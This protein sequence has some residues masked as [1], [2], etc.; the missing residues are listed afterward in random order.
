[1]KK[2]ALSFFAS[3]LLANFSF[4]QEFL[5]RPALKLDLSLFD[6]P[7][8]IG[9]AKT[10]EYGFFES[11]LH[12]TMDASLNVTNGVYSSL[13]FGLGKLRAA[14]GTDAYWK[15]VAYYGGTM[16]G[17]FLL[18]MLPV[19]AGFFWM[20]ESFHGAEFTHA[21][22]RNHMDYDFP[23]GA[24]TVGD[25][26]NFSYWHDVPRTVAAGMEGEVLL[27]DKMQRNNFFYDQKM[28]HE[29]AYWLF[30]YQTWSYAYMP[31]LMGDM[32]MTIDGKEEAVSADSLQWAYSLFHPHET[33]PDEQAITMSDLSNGAKSYLENR[34]WWSLANF[35]SPM[36]F[37]I[38]SIPLGRD[39][40]F[41]GNFALRQMY[42]SFGTDLSV[43]IY[44]KKY[45]FNIAFA[46][47][48]YVNYENYFPAIEAE[49]VDYPIQITPKFG[50]LLSPRV[51]L[52]MQPRGQE[53]M[54]SEAEFFGLIGA[55][56]D[57]AVGG[58]FLPYLAF[59]LKTDGWVAGDE[60][61]EKNAGIKFGVS[62]RL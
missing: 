13:H 25:S 6:V 50:L 27:V 62:A 7:Y 55:R 36:M 49:L 43:N 53:F 11:Y 56:V 31:F 2:A 57:F 45:P 10:L 3:F 19:P 39:T 29:F 17:D 23:K 26:G 1:M 4:A 33:V 40:G 52:G 42:T 20:H 14:I 47:H 37:G 51:M 18:Y 59:V 34:V 8:Q 35:V 12:P 9:A 61:L 54:A 48:N 32:T 41:Y 58:H 44:L 30:A 46:Y 15:R 38:R 24:Y 5:D 28:F 16:A 21:G 60:F 22:L